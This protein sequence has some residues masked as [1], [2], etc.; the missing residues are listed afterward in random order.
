MA[1]IFRRF[2]AC[3]E[4]GFERALPLSVAALRGN[5]R[6]SRASWEIRRRSLRYALEVDSAPFLSPL[7]PEIADVYPRARFLLLIRDCFSWMDSVLEHWARSGF[8]FS[9]EPQNVWELYLQVK[10]GHTSNEYLPE[11]GALASM[12]LPAVG[13]LMRVWAESNSRLLLEVPPDRLLVVR[14]EDID[15]SGERIARFCS[16]DSSELCIGDRNLAPLRQGILAGVPPAHAVHQAELHCA[17]LMERF[18]GCDWQ[19]L[20]TRVPDWHA[21]GLRRP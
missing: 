4:C 12:D 21:P 8:A 20:A 16:V 5:L 13:V 17:S 3:H 10:Y 1:G 15:A 6:S 7:V 18:W 11:D 19:D 2:R 14:T 9:R